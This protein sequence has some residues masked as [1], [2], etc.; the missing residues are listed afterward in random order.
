VG[1]SQSIIDALHDSVEDKSKHAGIQQDQM[2]SNEV[3]H[4]GSV[5]VADIWGML[6]HFLRYC[7]KRETTQR[8]V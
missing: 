3:P 1:Y 6:H 4:N 8:F 2:P 5:H 7:G